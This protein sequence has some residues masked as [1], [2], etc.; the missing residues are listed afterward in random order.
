MPEKA[1]HTKGEKKNGDK[2]EGEG[3]VGDDWCVCVKSDTCYPAI[4]HP[5][6]TQL[7]TH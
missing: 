3:E 5:T 6:A 2:K 7:Y 4:Y 1:V